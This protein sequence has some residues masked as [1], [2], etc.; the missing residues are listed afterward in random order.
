MLKVIFAQEAAAERQLR[1]QMAN[2]TRYAR[3]FQI[4][5]VSFLFSK[6]V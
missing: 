3:C 2:C 1:D 6:H 4:K 5:L